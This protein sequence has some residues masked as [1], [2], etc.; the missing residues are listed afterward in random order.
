GQR[1][2]LR[3]VVHEAGRAAHASRPHEG[4]NAVDLAARDVLAIHALAMPEAHPLLGKATLVATMIAGG[5]RPNMIPGECAITLDGRSTPAWGNARMLAALKAA[6]QGRV[7]VKSERFEPLVTGSS[8]EI[9]RAAVAESP[10]GRVTGYGGVSD[11]FHVRPLP[12]VV[13]GPGTSEQS[14]APDESVAAEQVERAVGVY[15]GIIRRY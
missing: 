13:L 11:L 5:T 14:H 12:G 15:G 4:V 7:E 8:E 2:L 1:G 9:V 6:V 10:A 3:A